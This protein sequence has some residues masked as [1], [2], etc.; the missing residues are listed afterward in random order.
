[1][2]DPL[3]AV[4]I[5]VGVNIISR[6]FEVTYDGMV[7][8]HKWIVAKGKKYDILGTAARRYAAQ[9]ERRYGTLRVLGM[10]RPLSLRDIY[11]NVNVLEKI[12]ERQSILLSELERLFDRDKR[13]FGIRRETKS[14]T[15]VANTLDRFIILGKP[16]AGKTTFLKHLMF[17]TLD[18]KSQNQRVPIFINLK[19]FSESQQPLLD[20]IVQEFDICHFPDAK[21]FITRILE[22]GH[23]QILMDGLDEVSA[24]Q[25]D[26]VISEIL[27][28]SDKYSDNQHVLSCRIAAYNHWF[29]SFTDVEIADFD[30]SQIKQ[31]VFNWFSEEPDVAQQCWYQLSK[32]PSILELA[33]VPLLLTLICL[34]YNET[35]EFPQ[36]R[37]ELYREALDALLKKWDSS[38]RI[39]RATIYKHLSPKRKE[40]MLARIAAET[41]EKGWYFLKQQ[42]LEKY[43]VRFIENL[44]EA[45]LE[46]LKPDSEGILRAIEAHHGIIVQR[47][48][49]IYSFSHLT[50]QEY[51]TARYIVEH[52]SEGTIKALVINHL[53]EDRWR[54]IFLLTA[55][56]LDITDSY[57]ILIKDTIDANARKNDLGV[58]FEKLR[59]IRNDGRK[60]PYPEVYDRALAVLN[61]MASREDFSVHK[62]PMV[63]VASMLLKQIAW[64]LPP[65][66]H[67]TK[68]SSEERAI[69]AELKRALKRARKHPEKTYFG[70]QLKLDYEEKGLLDYM[71]TYS[72][73]LD[74]LR[75]ECYVSRQ[76][77]EKIAA[78]VYSLG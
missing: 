57:L 38:R 31:F 74:C 40:S 56:M 3:Q 61:T 36:N 47:A 71:K 34:A 28:F 24:A 75:T 41:F 10:E 54:E 7:A 20:F 33:T 22:A 76:V 32:E 68:G 12:T 66:L 18:G 27:D 67:W 45:N 37:S 49:G 50:F 9:L 58:V 42:T 5:G 17:Q 13:S 11:V 8:A 51:F 65:S 26:Y 39:K 30:T 78:D 48:K 46:T 55:G 2:T 52:E 70:K 72:L 53:G 62:Q 64:E 43:I 77:R 63:Q 44:P 16:G 4:A 60:S 6:L 21:P 19:A 23:C 1:M 14:G 15:S 73:L 29:E 25:Q 69:M 59:D 35:M